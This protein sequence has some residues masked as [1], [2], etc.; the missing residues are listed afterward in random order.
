MTANALLNFLLAARRNGE[1]LEIPVCFEG[2]ELF[3]GREALS[4][5]FTPASE[6]YMA[7][8]DQERAGAHLLIYR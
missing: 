6:K 1:D 5:N 7:A 8:D 4:V 3:L 2:V